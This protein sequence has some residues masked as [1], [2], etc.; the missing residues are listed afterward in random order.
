MFVIE[1]VYAVANIAVAMLLYLYIGKTNPGLPLGDFQLFISSFEA[2]SLVLQW[3][4]LTVI[5][6]PESVPFLY[7][8]L[9]KRTS[10]LRCICSHALCSHKIW[11]FLEKSYCTVDLQYHIILV[12][13]LTGL[14]L[15][16]IQTLK[17]NSRHY[18][19]KKT[20]KEC[21]HPVGILKNFS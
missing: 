10:D 2:L 15:H 11:S 14:Q 21:P 13:R 12:F 17:R 4:T 6:Y 18:Q 19:E 1:W 5:R 9:C 20:M 8:Q 7:I 3:D 16:L